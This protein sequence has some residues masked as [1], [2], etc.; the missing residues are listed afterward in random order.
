MALVVSKNDMRAEIA[1]LAQASLSK[2]AKYIIYS[3]DDLKFR[4]SKENPLLVEA[5]SK[6]IGDQYAVGLIYKKNIDSLDWYPCGA[7][8]KEFKD[9]IIKLIN[10]KTSLVSNIYTQNKDVILQ[11]ISEVY[12]RSKK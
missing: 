1:R 5:Y 12:S 3:P 11:S 10:S 4:F 9:E 2:G 6:S 8:A 7:S